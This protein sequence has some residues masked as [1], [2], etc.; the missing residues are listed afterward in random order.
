M[1][2]AGFA[3]IVV[4]PSLILWL[5]IYLVYAWIGDHPRGPQ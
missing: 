2:W 3:E 4:F 1:T 5:S